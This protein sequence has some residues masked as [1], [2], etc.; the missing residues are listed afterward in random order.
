MEFADDIDWWA[1]KTHPFRAGLLGEAELVSH[2]RPD[3]LQR[4]VSRFGGIERSNFGLPTDG[5]TASAWE[6]RRSTTDYYQLGL[7]VQDTWTPT[8]R[9]SFSLGL[10]EEFRCSPRRF[11]ELRAAMGATDSAGKYSNEQQPPIFND[12]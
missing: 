11:R 7:Y 5:S 12:W 1:G 2:Q 6:A 10:R 4:R 9:V 8:K 3:E